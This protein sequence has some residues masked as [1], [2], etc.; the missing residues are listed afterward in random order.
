MEFHNMDLPPSLKLAFHDIYIPD[1]PEIDK[2]SHVERYRLD[3]YK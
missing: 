2:K 1:L 3:S